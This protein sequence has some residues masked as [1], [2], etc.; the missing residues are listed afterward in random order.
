MKYLG[1]VHYGGRKVSWGKGV[2]ANGTVFF[3][4]VEGIEPSTGNCPSD[5]EM[6]TKLAL[7]KTKIR[8]KEAGTVG[9][10]NLDR[11]RTAKD[12]WMKENYEQPSPTFASTLVLVAGLA[13]PDCLRHGALAKIEIKQW[14]RMT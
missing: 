9:R 3:S 7:E 13:R 6:Q 10:E 8:L 12:S 2:V 5:I 4:G 14:N 1:D 11:Y